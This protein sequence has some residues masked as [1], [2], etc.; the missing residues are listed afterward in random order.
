M[1]NYRIYPNQKS[2]KLINENHLQEIIEAIESG[3]YSFACLLFLKFS[4]YNPLLYLPYRTYNRLM[5]N[6]N[7]N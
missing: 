7:H 5:K 6:H 4:G 2:K 3:K 1:N